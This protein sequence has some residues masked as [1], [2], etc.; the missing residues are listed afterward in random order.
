MT[1]RSRRHP[2]WL[3]V[4][5]PGGA[6]Y[7][8]IKQQLRTAHLHTICEE[9]NCPNLSE[10][11]QKGTA[12]FLILGDTCT[13]NCQYCNVT[14]GT[15]DNLN[16]SEPQDVAESVK[17]LHLS[18]VVITSVTRDDLTDG[19]ARV[20]ADVI[21]AIRTNTPTCTIE[22]L[23][24]DF[25]GNTK[26]LHTVLDEKPDV[27]N[28]NIEVVKELFPNIRPEGSYQQSI[29]LLT[30]SK[31]YASKV[32]TKSG[33][34]VGLGETREQ[35]NQLLMDLLDAA[36]DILTIGQY[37]QPT[38]SHTPIIR[39]YTPDEFMELSTYAKNLGFT[40]V[41]SGPLVRSSYPVS[42]THLTLPTN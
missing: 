32:I 17:S 20:F 16:D 25:Q 4:P 38:S 24:P 9:A 34:M 39:Y 41:E 35:I 2:D 8:T 10:C 18:H 12:T 33:F 3:K 5:I 7:K 26:A 31:Q 14:H 21:K 29:H 22:V 40:Y 23:I 6:S 27:L 30:Q 36:V 19:G 1:R 13:R 11:F 37:L 28:H 42:Y 15:P